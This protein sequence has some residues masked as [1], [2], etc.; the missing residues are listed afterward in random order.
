MHVTANNEPLEKSKKN[1]LV[2]DDGQTAEEKRTQKQHLFNSVFMVLYLDE[3]KMHLVNRCVFK[4][5]CVEVIWSICSWIIF[6]NHQ[7]FSSQELISKESYD[8]PNFCQ[9]CPKTLKYGFL[10]NLFKYTIVLKTKISKETTKEYLI[11][12]LQFQIKHK[13]WKKRRKFY[14]TYFYYTHTY[15]WVC[16][17]MV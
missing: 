5:M 4:F 2:K 7:H 17:D 9:T 10:L 11:Y 8:S 3:G 1:W 12:L 14:S 13:T 16:P 15:T 6:L